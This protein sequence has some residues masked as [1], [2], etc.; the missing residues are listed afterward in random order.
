MVA[1]TAVYYSLTG[2]YQKIVLFEYPYD[3]M[4]F[5]IAL[6]FLFTVTG[7]SAFV[8]I[9]YD[10]EV[11]SLRERVALLEEYRFKHRSLPDNIT[12]K[13]IIDPKSDLEKLLKEN[14]PSS[15]GS[16]KT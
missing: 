7:F 9:G 4:V 8:F 2:I 5:P 13:A 10:R 15:T 11:R 12:F 6:V 3:Q 1:A 16:P 14:E